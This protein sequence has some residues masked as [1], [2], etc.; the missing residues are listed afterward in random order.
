MAFSDCHFLGHPVCFKFGC[1]STNNSKADL[2]R[3]YNINSSKGQFIASIDDD[4]SENNV[5]IDGINKLNTH[6]EISESQY[7]N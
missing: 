3:A 6:I 2:D 1:C 7:H 5:V 4:T